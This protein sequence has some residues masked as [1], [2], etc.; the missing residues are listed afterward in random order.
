M[1]YRIN[2]KQMMVVAAHGS[3]GTT[4]RDAIVAYALK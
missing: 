1:T 4:L 3:F 2:G